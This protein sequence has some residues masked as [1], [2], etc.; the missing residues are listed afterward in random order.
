[1]NIHSKSTVSAMPTPNTSQSGPCQICTPKSTWI[2]M[3][4][5]PDIRRR[6][7]TSS[8][9]VVRGSK[10]RGSNLRYFIHPIY[11]GNNVS[12][13]PYPETET[14]EAIEQAT[15]PNKD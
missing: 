14:K 12:E 15:K 4:Q 10:I 2:G 3:W 6:S 11:A 7:V 5:T 1:M 13:M 8:D 9:Q